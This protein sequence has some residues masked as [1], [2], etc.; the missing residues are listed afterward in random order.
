MLFESKTGQFNLNGQNVNVE[1]ETVDGVYERK[2][3]TVKNPDRSVSYKLYVT[4]Y[5]T[6]DYRVQHYDKTQPYNAGGFTKLPSLE[7]GKD[8][9]IFTPEHI[10]K[11]S[12]E[13]NPAGI[14]VKETIENIFNLFQRLPAEI[15]RLKQIDLLLAQNRLSAVDLK[16]NIENHIEGIKPNTVEAIGQSRLAYIIEIIKTQEDNATSETYLNVE[17]D[18]NG[19]TTIAFEL[20]WN[21]EGIMNLTDKKVR[22]K[23]KLTGQNLGNKDLSNLFFNKRF[24]DINKEDNEEEFNVLLNLIKNGSVDIQVVEEAD[25]IN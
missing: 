19:T 1:V 9:D 2:I 25:P 3:S 7:P 5:Y 11:A 18:A 16:S 17:T 24:S 15:E 10:A 8:L 6:D 20:I 14:G 4:K 22:L 21:N 13:S 12:I 23:V